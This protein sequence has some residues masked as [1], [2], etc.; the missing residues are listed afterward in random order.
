MSTEFEFQ[1]LSW[2]SEDIDVSE[3][4]ESDESSTSSGGSKKKAKIQ[5]ETLNYTI[6][7]FG[8]TREGVSASLTITGFRPFFYI[9]VP[10]NWNQL[11]VD[12]LL[13]A[14][15]YSMGQK[16]FLNLDKKETCLVER[17]DM[18]GFTNFRKFKFLKLSFKSCKFMRYAAKFF[19]GRDVV[20]KR[21]HAENKRYGIYESNVEPYLR[22][23]HTNSIS[24]CG[25]L[26]IQNSSP[27][28]MMTTTAKLD[29]QAYYGDVKNGD[30]DQQRQ[31]A[32][33]RV[34]SFDIE[35]TSL[36]GEFP[37]ARRDFSRLASVLYDG[38]K[39]WSPLCSQYDLITRATHLMA[40]IIGVDSALPKLNDVD[41]REVELATTF[42][43]SE[44]FEARPPPAAMISIIKSLM[45][46]LLAT[47]KKPPPEPPR[48][49][50]EDSKKKLDEDIERCARERAVESMSR[51]M[52]TSFPKLKGDPIIQIGATVHNYGERKVSYRHIIT[53]D[54]CDEI[55][56][57][58]DAIK[59][60]VTPCKTEWDVLVK[61]AELV[62]EIDPDVLTGYNIFGFDMQYIERRAH[63]LGCK[64]QVRNAVPQTQPKGRPAPWTPWPCICF[65]CSEIWG[66]IITL[67]THP[68]TII[69]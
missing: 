28:A 21:L 52:N 12:T 19:L 45:D 65:I 62:R 7:A 22:F 23:F 54:T 50:V 31:D 26:R 67:I 39:R 68:T 35:C 25:W 66:L 20:C 64:M 15:I 3:L 43:A 32:P 36:T 29:R 37:V 14:L 46:D 24:P 13:D 40:R 2:H 60:L 17:M 1:A 6:K 11:S 33:F 34:M 18:W 57:P 10:D 5:Q 63:E 38:V 59:T 44:I 49:L 61:F 51:R 16:A 27:A 42:S 4:D 30:P 41:S 53:L 9:K 56:L 55:P 47:I 8:R 58:E 69:S 48:L